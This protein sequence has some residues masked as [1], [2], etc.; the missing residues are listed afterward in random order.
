MD[1]EGDMHYKQNN[2]RDC[3]FR[4]ALL[5]LICVSMIGCSK[6][7]NT[8]SSNT[9][10]EDT[11]VA[12]TITEATKEDEGELI[13]SE[14]TMDE[15]S[16]EDYLTQ[17]DTKMKSIIWQGEGSDIKNTT[18]EL[19]GTISEQI[20]TYA[21]TLK[22]SKMEAVETELGTTSMIQL[23]WQTTNGKSPYGLTWFD[24][25][26]W[27]VNVFIVGDTIVRYEVLP[28]KYDIMK[29]ALGKAKL[30][31]NGVDAVELAYSTYL[32]TSVQTIT[33]KSTYASDWETLVA[34]SGEY[35]GNYEIYYGYNQSF[36]YPY[37]VITWK[38]ADKS[39][40]MQCQ[41]SIESNKI[42]GITSMCDETLDAIGYK[43]V[44]VGN[45][46]IQPTLANASLKDIYADY[47]TI[48]CAIPNH[49]ATQQWSTYSSFFTQNFGSA[50]MENEMKPDYVL[51]QEECKSYVAGNQAYVAV[52]D[53]NFK[54]AMEVFRENGIKVR[55]H[56]FVWHQQT[57]AWF[58]YEDYDTSKKL[59][60]AE[61][62]KLRMK[63]FI[64]AMI[65][66]LDQNYSDLIYTID[67]VNEAFNGNGTLGMVETNNLWYDTIGYEYVYY[68]FKY[69]KEAINNSKNMKEVTLIY[70][71]YSMPYKVDKVING[72][73]T[74][75]KEKGED[76]H[77][78]I[79]AVGF[80][81]HY[82]T[83]TSM[84]TVAEAVKRFCDVGY[85]V[86]FTE[87]DIGIPNIVVGEA[88]TE[89]E[90][91]LQGEK[92]KS[93]MERLVDLKKKGYHITSISVWGINDALS[94]R[95]NSNG[96]NAYALL[97]NRDMSYKPAYYGMALDSSVLSYFELG[98]NY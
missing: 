75:F 60:D 32:D 58:F 7:T 15:L 6:E 88:P 16:L 95:S 40:R 47:F 19:E 9:G 48:G 83:S 12:T 29:T 8:T 20:G 43:E 51:N 68:A 93:L 53:A 71:D 79:D 46:K 84:V 76:V 36:S 13:S 64:D 10:K 81:G 59:V 69:A 63:N 41:F 18:P 27:V 98:I 55:Y 42:I 4:I 94:W 44:S 74:L 1:W 5:L 52:S 72:L 45:D 30:M 26:E 14:I 91:R 23:F 89:D 33:S 92:F 57:P 2:K 49:V 21:K 22:T 70:N 86:Q 66:L 54:K 34:K 90:L 17:I 96:F 28:C 80:Q 24:G 61:T 25:S 56:T 11:E 77:D 67:V 78:Y 73:D 37:A 65:Q 3:I 38:H 85:E 50:T 39:I 62:M 35:S 97:L 87:L 82:D 31:Q